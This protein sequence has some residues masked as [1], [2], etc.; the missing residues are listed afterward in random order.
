[1]TVIRIL[2]LDP[3]LANTGWAV[4]DVDTESREIV[5][6]RAHGTIVTEK[7]K[8]KQV[9]KSS[10]DLARARTTAQTLA[11]LIQEH[12][13]KLAASEVPS[14]AQSAS[15]SRAFGIVVGLLASLPIPIIEVSPT[16]V[17]MAVA[18]N[19]IADKEDI[20][21]W[22]VELTQRVGG[23]EFW[24]TSKAKNDWEIMVLSRYVTKT[25]EHQADAIASAQA[26]IKSEQFRQLT[27]FLASF[28][29]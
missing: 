19:K 17:K 2:G 16:E 11:K 29:A 6:V 7:T 9:R 4:L 3:S 15:A 8:N 23:Q 18:G 26:A 10:D 24:N 22:A 25:M 28:L 20:V 27:G 12:N 21:R 5:S 14:G 1:M 13:I